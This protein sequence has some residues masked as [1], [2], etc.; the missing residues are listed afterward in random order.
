MRVI[1]FR[2]R[3]PMKAF[4]QMV[5]YA[6]LARTEHM[7]RG[8]GFTLPRS[9]REASFDLMLEEMDEAG[10]EWGVVPGRISPVLGTIEADDIAAIVARRPD[11]LIGY[12]G[13]DPV[14]CRKAI[15]AIDAAVTMGMKGLVIEPGLSSNPMHLDD[16]RMYP[17]YAHCQ[18]LKVPVLFMAGGNA[19]PDVTYTSP[20]HIDRV[21]RD[22][23]HMKIISGHGNWPWAAQMIHVCYRRPNI[24]LSP[25]MYIFGGMPGAQD[26]INAANG[27]MAE[28]FL[29]ATAYPLL[30]FKDGVDTFLRFP[31]KES[32][33]DRVL[34]KNAAELLGLKG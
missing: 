17:L 10:V 14:D 28:R 25:D 20:E 8:I 5:M 1:D 11:R 23:P 22:F 24:W 3:P 19:G 9:V 15:A 13:I 30:P 6:N 31:L 16:A 18:D 34:Y 21:A 29:F 2:L 27:F 26:Y 12:A 7:A 4:L 33:I 32:V